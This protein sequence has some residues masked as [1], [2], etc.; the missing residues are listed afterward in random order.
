M[1]D[2]LFCYFVKGVE[3]VCL[4]VVGFM[5]KELGISCIYLEK[6]YLIIKLLWLIIDNV[7]LGIVIIIEINVLY[8]D[9]I[10]YFG[11]GD[12]EVYMVYQFLL[13]LLVLYVV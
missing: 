2:V 10:V 4:D 6:I 13:L 3:Y 1:V 11:V 7:V 5:W 9:N 8:K 12:D